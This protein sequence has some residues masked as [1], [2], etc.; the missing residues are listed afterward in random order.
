MIVVPHEINELKIEKLKKRFGNAAIRYSQW[1]QKATN[2]QVLIIDNIGML[3]ALYQYADL[4]YIG[5][6]FGK[7]I[8]NILEAVVYGTPVFFGPNYRKFREAD[9]LVHWKGAFSVKNEKELRSRVFEI[10]QE[11]GRIEKIKEINKR[12]INNNKGATELIINYL[13]LN[14]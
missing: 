10:T 8:H 1:D 6:G 13:K 7:G 14:P 4:A 2:A 5:G 11:P 12:Y 9:E 3:S